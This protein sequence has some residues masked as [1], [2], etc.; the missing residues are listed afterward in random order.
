MN[1]IL[2]TI[3]ISGLL[4]APASMQ[5]INFTPA[6]GVRSIVPVCKHLGISVSTDGRLGLQFSDPKVQNL[7]GITAFTIT[8]AYLLLSQ[9]YKDKLVKI[10]I[11]PEAGFRLGF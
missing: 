5:A 10:D 9:K 11:K 4:I 8:I 6:L 3:I 7:I 2:K 1:K